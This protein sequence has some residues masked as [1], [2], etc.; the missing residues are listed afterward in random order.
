MS[1]KTG[2]LCVAV[3]TYKKPDGTEKKRYEN[4]GNRF[5]NEDGGVFF[6]IKRTFSP[7]GVPNPDNRDSILVSIFEK[8]DDTAVVSD[9]GAVKWED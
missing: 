4:I 3:G 2:D 5:E 8:K 9:A 1:K 6:S 7:S